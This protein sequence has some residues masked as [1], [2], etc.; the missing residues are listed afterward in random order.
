VATAAINVSKATSGALAF[1]GSS[2]STGMIIAIAAAAVALG[3][4]LVVAARRRTRAH[5]R[6]G[7]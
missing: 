1:T 5:S 6:L 7:T 2:D 4:V 3:S